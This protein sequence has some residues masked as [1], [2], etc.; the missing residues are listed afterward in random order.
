LKSDTTV[1]VGSRK[2]AF[3]LTSDGNG[4]IWKSV[5]LTLQDRNSSTSPEHLLTQTPSMPRSLAAGLDN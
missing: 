2:A 1:L 4:L 5:A 3:I